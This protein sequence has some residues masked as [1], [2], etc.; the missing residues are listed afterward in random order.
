MKRFLALIT[1]H[2]YRQ[3]GNGDNTGDCEWNRDDLLSD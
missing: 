2:Y 3:V 1:Y